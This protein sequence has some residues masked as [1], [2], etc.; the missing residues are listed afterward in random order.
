MIAPTVTSALGWFSASAKA[1]ATGAEEDELALEDDLGPPWEAWV[2]DFE[3]VSEGRRGI[4]EESE[5]SRLLQT[6]LVRSLA[7]PACSVERLE[8]RQQLNQF[9]LRS[10]EFVTNRTTHVPPITTADL[11]PFG[12]QVRRPRWSQPPHLGV[13]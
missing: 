9:L 6:E 7:D 13:R 1:L 10:L 8:L 3:A 5:W 11:Q 12:L 2:L 4:S